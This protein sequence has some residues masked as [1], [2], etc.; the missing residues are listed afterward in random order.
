[1]PRRRYPRRGLNPVADRVHHPG[2]ETKDH[3]LVKEPTQ[4]PPIAGQ[5]FGPVPGSE[6]RHAGLGR[7]HTT[8]HP[9]G[10]PEQGL[11]AGLFFLWGTRAVLLPGTWPAHR[12]DS[13]CRVQ[14]GSK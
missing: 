11:R 3:F 9:V 4:S 7:L 13:S 10:D 14:F 1:M 6:P 5:V 8:H 12:S 2:D